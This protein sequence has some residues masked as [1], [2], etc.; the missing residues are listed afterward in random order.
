M[1]RKRKEKK[2]RQYSRKKHALIKLI[3]VWT[4]IKEIELCKSIKKGKTI[5]KTQ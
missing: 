5:Q 3:A 4:N 2:I 1:Y